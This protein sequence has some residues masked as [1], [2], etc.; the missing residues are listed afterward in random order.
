MRKFL[1][2]AALLA[3]PSASRADCADDGGTIPRVV[4]PKGTSLAGGGGFLTAEQPRAR[5]P[6]GTFEKTPVY[7]V[8]GQTAKET[9]L[10]PG[11]VL[12]T[13]TV[14]DQKTPIELLDDQAE[15]VSSVIGSK[16]VVTE[17]K[18]PAVKAVHSALRRWGTKVRVELSA[19]VLKGTYALVVADAKGAPRVFIPV[20]EGATSIEEQTGHCTSQPAG[21]QPTNNGDKVTLFWVDVAGRVSARTKPF[22]VAE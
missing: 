12:T 9:T 22:V 2:L 6:D 17:F 18:A 14:T 8:K 3:L 4:T 16:A 1:V 13:V 20:T 5:N 10:A 19:P 15:V 11:L 21:T 7:R